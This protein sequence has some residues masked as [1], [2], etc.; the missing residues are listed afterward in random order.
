MK[1]LA[2]SDIFNASSKSIVYTLDTLEYVIGGND[3][4]CVSSVVE[5]N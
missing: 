3:F 2:D 1:F 5:M 4:A